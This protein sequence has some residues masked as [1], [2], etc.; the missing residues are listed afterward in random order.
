MEIVTLGFHED[1]KHTTEW[2]EGLGGILLDAWGFKSA[3]IFLAFGTA[4]VIPIAFSLVDQKQEKVEQEHNT[5]FDIRTLIGDGDIL[6][7]RRK[8]DHVALDPGGTV[9]P[10]AQRWLAPDND[11]IK[12]QPRD[13]G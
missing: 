10:G 6:H 3:S 5:K 1:F 12:T 9:E 7:R 13:N 8:H 11:L 4:L 2:Q